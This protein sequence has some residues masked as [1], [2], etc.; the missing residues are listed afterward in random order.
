MEY[1]KSFTGIKIF[2][3]TSKLTQG[4]PVGLAAPYNSSSRRL[5]ESEGKKKINNDGKVNYSVFI[6][7]GSFK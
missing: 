3:L 5:Q 7:E 1:P 4:F 2:M 6:V